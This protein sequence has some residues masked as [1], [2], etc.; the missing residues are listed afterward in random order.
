MA[1]WVHEPDFHTPAYTSA[2]YRDILSTLH[3]SRGWSSRI[4]QVCKKKKTGLW[5]IKINPKKGIENY[6][7][8]VNNLT[9][10]KST[11]IETS[12]TYNMKHTI[13]IN[14]RDFWIWWGYQDE[15]VLNVEYGKSEREVVGIQENWGGFS[16]MNSAGSRNAKM[17]GKE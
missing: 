10:I 8:T 12:V 9:P 6:R 7:Y 5:N 14:K 1:C 15:D 17:T 3:N 11:N 16:F 4:L 2:Q 13:F